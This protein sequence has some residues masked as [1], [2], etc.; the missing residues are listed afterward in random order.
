MYDGKIKIKVLVNHNFIFRLGIFFFSKERTHNLQLHN[1]NTPTDVILYKKQNIKINK[2]LTST[3][4]NQKKKEIQ[5]ISG[6][7]KQFPC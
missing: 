2:N 7:Q 6:L 5:I 4:G 3:S 1:Q